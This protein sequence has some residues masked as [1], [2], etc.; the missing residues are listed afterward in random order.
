MRD[1]MGQLYNATAS[2]GE[3]KNTQDHYETLLIKQ[4]REFDD[5]VGDLTGFE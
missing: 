3:I 1:R 2:L 4:K 5:L